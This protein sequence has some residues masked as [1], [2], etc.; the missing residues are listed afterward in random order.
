MLYPSPPVATM[1]TSGHWGDAKCG[2]KLCLLCS[3]YTW[4]YHQGV[5]YN[6]PKVSSLV[7]K[8]TSKSIRVLKITV[9]S[10]I[11]IFYSKILKSFS[12]SF[13]TAN[14]FYSHL[15][16]FTKMLLKLMAL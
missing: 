5:L 10:I 15:A 8:V 4:K 2:S 1:E 3:G 13:E 11:K 16:V 6:V 9:R 12:H 7:L 14:M